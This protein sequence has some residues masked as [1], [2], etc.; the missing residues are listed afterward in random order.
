MLLSVALLVYWM[1]TDARVGVFQPTVVFVQ[2]EYS[3]LAEDRG[4]L[5][6]T[7]KA[8]AEGSQK[9][10]WLPN[11]SREIM[12]KASQRLETAGERGRCSMPPSAAH[13]RQQANRTPYGC[14]G[15]HHRALFSP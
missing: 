2:R 9:C 14:M 3:A 13:P 6:L 5:Q 4:E 1:T 7:W 8:I 11:Q 15:S 12:A 10:S